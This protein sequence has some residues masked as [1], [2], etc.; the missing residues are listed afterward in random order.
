L[1]V[2]SYWLLFVGYRELQPNGYYLLVASC[3]LLVVEKPMTNNKQQTTNNKQQ[4]V[5]F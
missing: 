2:V 3:E 4:I 1:L 5:N